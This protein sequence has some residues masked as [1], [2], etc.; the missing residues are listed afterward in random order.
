MKYEKIVILE[1]FFYDPSLL[2]AIAL[3]MIEPFREVIDFTSALFQIIND[4]IF[5]QAD[6]KV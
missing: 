3:A 4:M 6:N 2:F 1:R 5:A